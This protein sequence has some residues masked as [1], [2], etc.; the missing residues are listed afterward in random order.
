MAARIPKF[1]Q[2]L[3][4][5][6]EALQILS[7][8]PAQG[9]PIGE[10]AT[11]LGTTEYEIRETLDS[12]SRGQYL[13]DDPGRVMG[14]RIDFYDAP[15]PTGAD[16]E[17]LGDWLDEHTVEPDAAGW[18]RLVPGD[19]DAD[20]FNVMLGVEQI[21][22]LLT[23]ADSLFR[24]EPGNEDL[25][26]AIAALRLHWFPDTA[27]SSQFLSRS[28][29]LPL[30]RQ[31]I[32]EKRKVRFTYSREWQPGVGDRVVEP[33]ALR[34]TYLGFELDAGPVGANGRIRTFLLRNIWQIEMLDDRFE[35][36][37]DVEALIAANRDT[38]LVQLY[39]PMMSKR[40][41]EGLMLDWRVVKED[42]PRPDG[43]RLLEVELQ[44][45]F[46]ERL[47]MIMFRAGPGSAVE[48]GPPELWDAAARRAQE[49][50]VHHGLD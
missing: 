21:V 10:L 9:L 24:T 38:V 39:V 25:R 32:S 2:R 17:A 18:V 19:S 28:S 3:G 13:D 47:A 36:P 6:A 31:A 50:L 4:Q 27:L 14:S 11:L 34:R 5:T 46:A 44:Q 45:P 41:Y 16:E 37:A 26:E 29:S 49:L 1:A 20:P 30:I 33:Y 23:C 15:I 40:T 42:D 48:S 22:E 8:Y 12:F 7:L 35:R 43:E